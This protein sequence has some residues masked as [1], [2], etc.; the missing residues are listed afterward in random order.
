MR[1][2]PHTHDPAET[3]RDIRLPGGCILCGGDLEVR[4]TGATAASFCTV[5]HWISKPHMQRHED[6]IHVVHPA[7]GIA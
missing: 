1:R 3:A 7:G 2:E 4:V 5:C 6:G